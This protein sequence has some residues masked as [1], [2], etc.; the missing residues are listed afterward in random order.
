MVNPEQIFI[1]FHSKARIVVGTTSLT[2]ST[3][4][5]LLHT[6]LKISERPEF[7]PFNLFLKNGSLRNGIIVGACLWCD[8]FEF[9]KAAYGYGVGFRYCLCASER[10]WRGCFWFIIVRQYNTVFR[11][12][13]AHVGSWIRGEKWWESGNTKIT[14]K[15]YCHTK[16]IVFIC[17]PETSSS[18]INIAQNPSNK[19]IPRNVYLISFDT[20][21]SVFCPPNIFPTAIP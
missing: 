19:S 7:Y 9:T 10:S 2:I 8:L 15:N 18:W 17:K 1:Y 14:K 6:F 21:G 3:T 16:S 11:L 12:Y 13:C 20:I 5:P 4:S